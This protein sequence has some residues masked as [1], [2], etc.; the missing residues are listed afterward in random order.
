[1]NFQE[2]FIVLCCVQVLNKDIST[3]QPQSETVRDFFRNLVNNHMKLSSFLSRIDFLA[4]SSLP[5]D[6]ADFIANKLH[7]LIGVSVH[8]LQEVIFVQYS[9]NN[10][11]VHL[12]Y[13]AIAILQY[14]QL[15]V[16]FA[17]CECRLIS[18][19]CEVTIILS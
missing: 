14:F 3:D 5:I 15:F 10:L 8:C 7:S 18:V 11:I 16:T 2:I 4:C 1:M 13:S 17:G 9:T 12:K 6:E 19:S